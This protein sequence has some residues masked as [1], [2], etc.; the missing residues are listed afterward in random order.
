M[1]GVLRDEWNSDGFVVSDR[2]SIDQLTDHGFA[3]DFRDA[4]LK[5]VT[6]GVYMELVSRTYAD[7]LAEL[8][9]QGETAI[10]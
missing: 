8:V 6:A 9:E 5:A 10:A 2:D 1:Q 7:H 3:A 4:A